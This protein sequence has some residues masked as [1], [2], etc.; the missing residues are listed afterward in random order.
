MNVLAIIFYIL[1]ILYFGGH[2]LGFLC[3]A[4]F[5]ILDNIELKKIEKENKH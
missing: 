3:N 1:G 2:I 4:V 5:I